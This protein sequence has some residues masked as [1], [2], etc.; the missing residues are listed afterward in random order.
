VAATPLAPTAR[1]VRSVAFVEGVRTP[2][3]KAG[4]KGIYAGTRADDADR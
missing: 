3:G 1:A 2:F 4:E